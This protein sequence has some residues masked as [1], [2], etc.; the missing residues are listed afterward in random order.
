MVSSPTLSANIGTKMGS[1]TQCGWEAGRDT[2]VPDDVERLLATVPEWFGRPDSN[3]EYI[4]AARSL[5]TWTVRDGE[6]HVIGV[7]LVSHHFPRS[8]EIH[9]TVVDR[10]VHGQGVGS[11]MI[12]AIEDDLRQRGVDILSV[13]TLG[14]SHPDPNYACT[15]QFYETVGFV[16]LE[17]TELWGADTPCLIM[18]KS[19]P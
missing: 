7:T 5:E 8:S 13:K 12:R 15:R 3:A 4:E 18:V 10:D 9:L 17:E 6:D 19:L 14:H 16:P 2:P 1:M 11:A